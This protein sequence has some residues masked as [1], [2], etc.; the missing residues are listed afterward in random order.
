MTHHKVFKIQLKTL[1]LL[2][3]FAKA[4]QKLTGGFDVKI[5]DVKEGSD[6]EGQKSGKKEGNFAD[7]FYRTLYELVLKVHMLKANKM[8]DYFALI[9]KAVKHDQDVPRVVAFIRRL[10]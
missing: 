6:D 1:M 10:L 2:F 7:R 4:S 5:D 3:Q 8:D 9:F